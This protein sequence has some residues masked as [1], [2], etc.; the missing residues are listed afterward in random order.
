[1]A[2]R[3]AETALRDIDV[4]FRLGVVSGMSDGQLVE[5]VATGAG[6]DG[7]L[8]FDA[9]VRRHGPMV[10]GVCRRVLGDYHAAEDAFQATF[11]VLAVNAR[12][13]RNQESLGPWLHGVA[14]RVARRARVT[15]QRVRAQAVLSAAV[16]ATSLDEPA[17]VDVRGVID[18]E[19]SRLPEKYRLPVVLCYLEGRTQDE[20]ARTLGWT[21]GTVSGRL[22]RAKDLLRHRL[23]RRGLAPAAG[24]LAASLSS[25]AAPAA[26]PLSLVLA[27]VQAGTGAIHGGNTAGLVTGR[28]ALLVRAAVSAIRVGRL[29]RLAAQACVLALGAAAIGTPIVLLRAPSLTRDRAGPRN[30][31]ERAISRVPTADLAPRLDRFGDP[32]PPRALMRLGTTQRRHPREIAGIGFTRDGTAAISAQDDGTVRFWSTESGRPI[33]TINL[34]ADAPTTDQLVRDFAISRDG[35]LMAAAGFAFDPARRRMAQRVWIWGLGQDRLRR[36]IEV[37]TVDLFCVAFAPDGAKLATGGFAGAVQLWDV[38]TG[39]CLATRKLGASSV[40]SLAF[41]PD[42]Q[43]VAA[44]E[45]GKG[46]RLWDIE[47]DRET[48]IASSLSSPVAPVFSPDGRLMAIN[49][50][51]GEF[52]LWDRATGQTRLAAEGV[53]V[54]FAP[55][56]RSLAVSSRDGGALMVIDTPTGTELW[57]TE[58]GWGPTKGGLAFAPD[59]KTIVTERS[60]VLRFFEAGSGRERLGTPQ[61]H[62]GGVH[63]VRYT[64]AGR[65]IVTAGADGTVRT[66]DAATAR[67]LLVISHH[68]PAPTVAVSADGTSLATA[69]QGPEGIVT[70]WDLATG[71]KRQDWPG[72]GDVI[73]TLALAFSP[74]GGQLLAFDHD[75]GLR[76]LDI[77][78]GDERDADQPRFSL[79][80]EGILNSWMGRGAFSPGN[81][82]LAI[83]TATTVYLADLATS[84][85]RFRAPAQAL[86]FGS[87]G[88]SLLIATPGKPAMTQLADGSFRA[89]SPIADGIDL[90][91]LTTGERTRIE[92]P[93]EAVSALAVSPDGKAVAVA[94]GWISPT[95][96]LYRWVD[97]RELATFVCPARVTHADALSFSPNGRGLAAGLDDTTVLIWDISDVR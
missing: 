34:L 82:F 37:P 28:V 80:Q 70:V 24:V 49:S 1:M 39:D 32:L 14:A 46:T 69:G 12:R 19:L 57:K 44:C 30:P 78:T 9:I 31:A 83:H 22:A 64:P 4:L 97:G 17:A 29:G 56:S 73:G 38:A 71:L 72:T 52:A 16:V 11:M 21:K 58:L 86:A 26:V 36:V 91:S 60:G 8:A 43:V 54:A 5:R 63:V 33:G 13:I 55:D 89:G 42:G 92:V 25:E 50:L 79:D 84:A 93:R 94:G 45:Q 76:V 74:D 51:D 3:R 7:E 75:H 88:Q 66:W 2:D 18:E 41:A 95:V 68:N 62:Q 47:N 53:A 35:R 61:A 85:E 59:G 27:T 6:P 40:H 65:T 96:S 23:T 20:A 90:V 81:Q 15:R 77:A 67:Q 87:D 10:L 48:F